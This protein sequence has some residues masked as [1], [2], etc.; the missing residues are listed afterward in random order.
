M[1][2]LHTLPDELIHRFMES[3]NDLLNHVNERMLNDPHAFTLIGGQHNIQVMLDNH[4]NHISFIGI[5][6]K[7]RQ[8]SL[9][10][11]T[12]P[13]VYQSYHNQGFSYDYFPYV[14]KMWK[15]ALW[16]CIS[17][18][19]VSPVQKLYDV[20]I[21]LHKN[22]MEKS[23]ELDTFK[24]DHG[25]NSSQNE[26][27][28]VLLSGNQ[29]GLFQLTDAYM[30]E[31]NSIEGYYMQL[32]QPVMYAIG[33]K[34]ERGEISVAH[35]HLASAMVA[36]I[37]ASFYNYVE[38]PEISK[39]K[40]L[41]SSAANEYHEIGAWMTAN[42]FEL[43]GWD[44]YYLGANTPVNDLLGILDSFQPDFL[45]LSVTMAYNLESILNIIFSI[46]ANEEL[47]GIQILLGGHIFSSF[48]ELRDSLEADYIAEDFRDALEYADS[49]LEGWS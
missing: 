3:K 44:V 29:R 22:N 47:Q 9:L 46:K 39:G 31:G 43:H 40:I 5:V 14:L 38:L 10:L 7:L 24:T 11:K 30:T 25:L 48:P 8:T 6:L 27:L 33:R 19:D 35:E 21:D 36:R 2:D 26:Y 23:R 37:M 18:V 41:I 34:W 1:I 12:L 28:Q 20:M 32:V 4:R 13:W 42:M 16:A 15:E 45:G 17:D 49:I